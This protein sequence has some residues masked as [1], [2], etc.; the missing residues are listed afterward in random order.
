MALGNYLSFSRIVG[1]G[2]FKNLK[3]QHFSWKNLWFLVSSLINFFFLGIVV[4]DQNWLFENLKINGFRVYRM[5][6]IHIWRCLCCDNEFG[7][8]FRLVQDTLDQYKFHNDVDVIQMDKCIKKIEMI[9]LR[10]KFEVI[11]QMV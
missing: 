11:N 4:I 5:L 8:A 2:Y 10:T 3:D 1:Y 9:N 6:G 7:L